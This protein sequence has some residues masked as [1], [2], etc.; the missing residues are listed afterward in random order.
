MILLSACTTT[1]S[2]S[3]PINVQ[4]NLDEY[5]DLFQDQLAIEMKAETR[6][7]CPRDFIVPDCSAWKRAINDYGY[8]R[9]GIRAA[10]E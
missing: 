7:P 1:N 4:P 9:N 5:S 2:R 8:L 3:A 6:V 10:G